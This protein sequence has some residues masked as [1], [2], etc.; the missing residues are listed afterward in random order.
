MADRTETPMNLLAEAVIARLKTISQRKDS[1]FLTS[2]RAV[3]RLH[4]L[5]DFAGAQKPF[6]ALSTLGWE[7]EPQAG[8][9]F[10]GTLT[11]GVHCLAENSANAEGELLRLVSDVILALARDV[12]VGSQ[13]VYLFPRSFEPNVDLTNRTG[14]AVTTVTFECKYK[15]DSTAP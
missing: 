11:L 9:R 8:Q 3:K 15:F 14:L 2:P 13:A 4:M 10:E 7:V 6:L 12:T 5:G 1:S